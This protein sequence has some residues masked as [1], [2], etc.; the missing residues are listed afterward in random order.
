MKLQKVKDAVEVRR[1]AVKKV[2][3]KRDPVA[4]PMFNIPVDIIWAS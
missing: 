3:A 2:K 1:R 4:N